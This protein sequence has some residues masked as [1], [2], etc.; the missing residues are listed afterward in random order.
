MKG[1]R[2][3]PARKRSEHSACDAKSR[4]ERPQLNAII[5][6]K[7]E[8]EGRIGQYEKE[9]DG[10]VPKYD[11]LVRVSTEHNSRVAAL[12]SKTAGYK[13]GHS[14]PKED[15]REY[16]SLLQQIDAINLGWTSFYSEVGS[17][18]GLL[19]DITNQIA[20]LEQKKEALIA[21]LTAFLETVPCVRDEKN[22]VSDL[23][24]EVRAVNVTKTIAPM[25]PFEQIDVLRPQP[26]VMPE[27]PAPEAVGTRPRPKGKRMPGDDEDEEEEEKSITI[28]GSVVDAFGDNVGNVKVELSNSATGDRIAFTT[29]RDGIYRFEDL[30]EGTYEVTIAHP[31]YQNTKDRVSV[32]GGKKR[33]EP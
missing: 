15:A 1:E 32:K 19:D 33:I 23:I 14:W 3:T 12:D 29:A 13:P 4:K 20:T 2:C 26:P 11:E 9:L 27:P 25:P 24:A 31:A 5:S 10:L 21:D 8:I 7:R 17:V 6:L 30:E 16:Q 18:A 28:T 22:S